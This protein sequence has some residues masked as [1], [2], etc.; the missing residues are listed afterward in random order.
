MATFCPACGGL[1]GV[2]H[3]EGQRRQVCTKCGRVHYRNA[4]ACAG[5]IVL[6][7]GRVLLSLRAREPEKGRWDLPGGFLEEHEHPEQAVTRE[8]AEETGLKARSARYHGV[9]VGR[10]GEAYTLN[11]YYVVEADGEPVA[12]DDSAALQWWPLDA[13]PREMAWPHEVEALAKVRGERR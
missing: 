3:V 2:Q 12:A 13:L 11:F 10:Y 4:K 1:L 9:W 5:A 6:R 7:G 8:L